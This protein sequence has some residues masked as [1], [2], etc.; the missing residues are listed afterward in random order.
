[1]R[2]AQDKGTY[3]VQVTTLQLPYRAYFGSMRCTLHF[4]ILFEST[5]KLITNRKRMLVEDRKKI[6]QMKSCYPTQKKNLQQ[7]KTKAKKQNKT[8]S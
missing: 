7:K 3:Y 4:W 2:Y 8:S 1:M 6:K 5:E